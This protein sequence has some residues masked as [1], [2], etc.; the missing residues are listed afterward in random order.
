MNVSTH[1]DLDGGDG[2]ARALGVKLVSFFD[3]HGVPASLR[4]DFRAGAALGPTSMWPPRP[5]VCE[6]SDLGVARMW[7]RL[8]L[9]QW[10]RL[11][12]HA[13]GPH[14][15]FELERL[16]AVGARLRTA[17]EG[18]QVLWAIDVVPPEQW[19]DHR[20]TALAVSEL[21]VCG[22]QLSDAQLAR[23]D[24]ELRRAGWLDGFVEGNQ[25]CTV[26]RVRCFETSW[27]QGESC[28]T[29]PRALLAG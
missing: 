9:A 11:V 1:Q 22:P 20:R 28:S 14:R 15:P 24:A 10:L 7:A 12:P 27:H 25:P 3:D 4:S 5:G 18:V 21:V 6:H 23:A 19:T 8:D 26:N 13:F 17:G 16:A 29:R 2:G